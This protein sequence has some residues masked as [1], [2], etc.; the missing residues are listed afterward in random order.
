[1]A[2]TISDVFH[3]QY[4][5]QVLDPISAFNI[6]IFICLIKCISLPRRVISLPWLA[7]TLKLKLCDH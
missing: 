3:T 6:K 1:M 4:G 2:I 7:F 5:T